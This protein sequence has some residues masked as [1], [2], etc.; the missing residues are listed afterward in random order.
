MKKFGHF[1]LIE[2]IGVGGF[3]SVWKARDTDLDREVAIKIPRKNQLEP[4]EMEKFFREARASAQLNHRNIV[5]VHEVGRQDETVY[6]V[7]DLI[8]GVPLDEW[9]KQHPITPRQSAELCMTLCD[10]VDHAHNAGVIHRDLKPGNILLDGDGRP[11]VM[12]FGLAKREAGEVTMTVE[13]RV[14]GTPSYMSPEQARGE[15]HDADRRTDVYSLGVILFQLLTGELPFRGT[16]RMLLH[17]VMHNEPRAPRSLNDGVPRDLETITLKCMQK[18][19]A[20]RYDT[21]G[22]IQEDLRRYLNGEPISAR[23]IGRIERAIRWSRRYPLVAG[24]TAAVFALCLSVASV[25]TYAALQIRES[26]DDAIVAK[27][28]AIKEQQQSQQA[29]NDEAKQRERAELAE[30]EA[31]EAAQIASQEANTAREVS[32]FLISMFKAST[33]F[34]ASGFLLGSTDRSSADMTAREILDRGTQKVLGDL[35]D[36]PTVQADLL[37]SIGSVYLGI[38]VPEAA[39]PLLDKS[40]SIRRAQLPENH[41]KIASLLFQQG[42]ERFLL[43]DYE[44]SEQLLR[45]SLRMRQLEFGED[46]PIVTQTKQVLGTVMVMASRNW[47][48]IDV[49]EPEVLLRDVLK[50]LE[51]T[52]KQD[53]TEYG[54]ALLAY[55]GVLNHRSGREVEQANL[56]KTATDVFAKNPDTKLLGDA[57]WLSFN[58]RIKSRLGQ[59]K[60]AAKLFSQALEILRNTLGAEHWA[61]M[62]IVPYFAESLAAAGQ[63]DQAESTL[64]QFE[65]ELQNLKRTEHPYYARLTAVRRVL[66]L[67]RQHKI[68]QA[69]ALGDRLIAG[70]N[71]DGNRVVNA[72]YQLG[73]AHQA[74]GNFDQAF[75]FFSAAVEGY[76]RVDQTGDHHGDFYSLMLTDTGVAARHLER[77]EESEELLKLAVAVRANEFGVGH[78]DLVGTIGELA[79][80]LAKQEDF[81]AVKHLYQSHLAQLRSLDAN[82]RKARIK[83]L[84]QL[85]QFLVAHEQYAES[86]STLTAFIDLK[87]FY[88][89][90]QALVDGSQEIH[91]DA[92]IDDVESSETTFD[93][94]PSP[95]DD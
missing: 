91:S 28:Q 21:A 60:D 32:N 71:H 35:A 73:Y 66:L 8:H 51:A 23:P 86:E 75:K 3:G 82:G 24:L 78:E 18:E 89:Q 30:S 67:I 58:A 69:T 6:I 64:L 55:C 74:A 5:S 45:K 38:N 59:R 39:G 49:D 36:H 40:L 61:V 46:H 14:L 42:Y 85:A 7:S 81:A 62:W 26:R 33:P 90:E 2:Q 11:H 94:N 20:R 43:G 34:D 63:F 65:S 12:D 88:E 22:D 44:K 47:I 83:T 16:P 9:L 68:D 50:R 95:S 4:D 31:I 80:T 53:S 54:F 25:S 93:Q 57:I 77:F 87:Q 70:P 76:R 48:D 92:D 29:R 1:E 10:A 15:G 27:D 37:E 41:P 52:S 72:F 84:D 79:T 56:L 19:P 17:Q 13:G